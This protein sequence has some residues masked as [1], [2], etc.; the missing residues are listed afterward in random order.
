VAREEGGHAVEGG[1]EAPK[2]VSPFPPGSIALTA[3]LVLPIVKQLRIPKIIRHGQAHEDQ[4]RM[5]EGAKG[6]IH[7]RILLGPGLHEPQVA[8]PVQRHRVRQER[9]PVLTILDPISKD[10]GVPHDHQLGGVGPR[11]RIAKAMAIRV[12]LHPELASDK[13]ARVVGRLQG[14]YRGIVPTEI[15]GAPLLDLVGEHPGGTPPQTRLPE[16]GQLHKTAQQQPDTT[17]ESSSAHS[18]PPPTLTA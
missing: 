18:S 11:P 10:D 16:H 3:A 8:H 17:H 2:Q 4:L 1:R 14:P 9:R 12:I 15:V 7:A 6:G 13:E 5:E